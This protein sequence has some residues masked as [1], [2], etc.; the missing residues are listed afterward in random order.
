ML[1]RA[2]T[3]SK[4]N[5]GN[6]KY[7]NGKRPDQLLGPPVPSPFTDV[8]YSAERGVACAKLRTRIDG[9]NNGKSAGEC[10]S[11]QV[12]HVRKNYTQK[13]FEKIRPSVFQ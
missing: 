9:V 7:E 5:E 2:N 3:P 6:K 11:L 13:I 8:L 1:R 4:V 12:Q 10:S